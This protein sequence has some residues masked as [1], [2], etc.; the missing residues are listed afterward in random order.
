VTL[1][2]VGSAFWHRATAPDSHDTVVDGG[3]R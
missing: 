2:N 3:P 1:G